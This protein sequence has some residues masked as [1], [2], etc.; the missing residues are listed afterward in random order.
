MFCKLSN[1]VKNPFTARMLSYEVQVIQL[2]T[3]CHGVLEKKKWANTTF[4]YFV[5]LL[6]T[7]INFTIFKKNNKRK[8]SVNSAVC[9]APWICKFCIFKPKLSSDFRVRANPANFKREIYILQYRE[10]FMQ[11]LQFSSVLCKHSNIAFKL[12][13]ISK[14]P[15]SYCQMVITVPIQ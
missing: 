5:N 13:K 10:R 11:I 12:S 3:A 2:T 6:A 14:T 7:F 1:G 15:I 4:L 8:T 9:Q